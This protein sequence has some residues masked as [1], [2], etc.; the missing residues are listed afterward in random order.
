MASF[1][2]SL[3]LGVIVA[4]I[5]LGGVAINTALEEINAKPEITENKPIII[6]MHAKVNIL[7][8]GQHVIIPKHI[9]I[10]P[11]LYKTHILDKYG[12]KDPKTYPLHTHDTTGLIHIESTDIRTFTLGQFF[13]V[14]GV[15]FNEDCIM[16][17][18]ND[19]LNKIRMYV[20][21]IESFEFNEHILKDGEVITIEY[22]S[23][24]GESQL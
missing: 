10:D 22:G 16:D 17:K 21:G 18:C 9:G 15:T 5:A 23:P 20:D 24:K 11:A 4:L 19:R 3:T 7:I 2:V 13:D 14:W 6:H 1:W 8:H 12:I